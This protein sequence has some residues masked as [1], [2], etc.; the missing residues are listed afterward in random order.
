M[1]PSSPDATQASVGGKAT[2]QAAPQSGAPAKKPPPSQS[3]AP[4]APAGGASASPPNS[5]APTRRPPVAATPTAAT[6]PIPARPKIVRPAPASGAAAPASVPGV[7]ARAEPHAR[8]ASSPPSPSPTH[9]A[10][11]K[12]RAPATPPPQRLAPVPSAV[13]RPSAAPP[14]DPPGM[15]MASADR[16]TVPMPV[17]EPLGAAMPVE[18]PPIVMPTVWA[19]VTPPAPSAP[20]AVDEDQTL[21]FARTAPPVDGPAADTP[22]PAPVDLYLPVPPPLDLSGGRDAPATEALETADDGTASPGAKPS[23]RLLPEPS[24][25]ADDRTATSSAQSLPPKAELADARLRTDATPAEV[26]RATAD[27]AA[28][29][30]VDGHPAK[31]A[32]VSPNNARYASPVSAV[33]EPVDRGD[34]SAPPPGDAPASRLIDHLRSFDN[35]FDVYVQSQAGDLFEEQHVFEINA[36]AQEKLWAVLERYGSGRLSESNGRSAA[37][38]APDAA[39]ASRRVKHPRQ[40]VI[41]AGGLLDE[42]PKLPTYGCGCKP[43]VS[44]RPSVRP[45]HRQ[46]RGQTKT[47][48]QPAIGRRPIPISLRPIGQSYRGPMACPK[49]PVKDVQAGRTATGCL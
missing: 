1:Q 28:E 36:T 9:T 47:R 35:P 6:A 27:A 11:S 17:T 21:A 32:D 38:G 19:A 13:L 37:G 48:P 22:R 40:S 4:V 43:E 34:G 41:S 26:D 12:P 24:A 23:A 14:T 49:A 10:T 31:V 16:V 46:R 42:S 25:T 30:A 39:D 2:G 20:V 5:Q 18:P 7:I 44:P 8:P 33:A 29:A 15:V 3:Q 45:T